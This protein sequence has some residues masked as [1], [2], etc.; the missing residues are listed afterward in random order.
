[1]YQDTLRRAL[2]YN[3]V[4]IHAIVI[5]GISSNV[6]FVSQMDFNEH[7]LFILNFIEKKLWLWVDIPVAVT[8]NSI[9]FSEKLRLVFSKKKI[10]IT[11]G[12]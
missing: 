1:M 7:R 6:R 11:G 12:G 2:R 10:H 5:F 9:R 8:T 3:I 4:V